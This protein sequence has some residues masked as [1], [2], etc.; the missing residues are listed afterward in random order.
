MLDQ[1]NSFFVEPHLV[2]DQA[3]VVQAIDLV[4]GAVQHG[5]VKL[6]GL[7]QLA[8]LVQAQGFL[9]RVGSEQLERCSACLA[10]AGVIWRL[11]I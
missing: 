8:L 3:Q 5:A 7:G 10:V 6:C 4:R 1:A 2:L 9:Q 11:G